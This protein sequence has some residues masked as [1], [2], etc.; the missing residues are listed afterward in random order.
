[1]PKAKTHKNPYAGTFAKSFHVLCQ[2]VVLVSAQHKS[3][4]VSLLQCAPAIE[5]HKGGKMRIHV[6]NLLLLVASLCGIVEVIGVMSKPPAWVSPIWPAG[7]VQLRK[8]AALRPNVGSRL[9]MQIM[10]PQG[11]RR[12]SPMDNLPQRGVEVRFESPLLRFELL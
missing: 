5:P 10:P 3:Y 6:F 11:L 7:K 2:A 12:S 4:I 8:A 1:M 9:K